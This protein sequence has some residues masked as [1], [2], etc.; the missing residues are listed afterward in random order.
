M[1]KDQILGTLKS[2]L[3]WFT[4]GGRFGS[5]R[6]YLSAFGALIATEQGQALLV[7]GGLPMTWVVWLAMQAAK[8]MIWG[9]VITMLKDHRPKA[10]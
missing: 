8:I 5:W 10:A 4:E 7:A 1:L 2:I 9:V 3:P 6:L